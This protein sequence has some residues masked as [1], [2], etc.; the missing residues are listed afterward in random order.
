MTLLTDDLVVE[1]A[2]EQTATR[3]DNRSVVV[4]LALGYCVLSLG[5]NCI[6]AMPEVRR[7][8][9]MS[10][11]ITSLH[12]SFFGWGLIGLSLGAGAMSRLLSRT[13]LFLSGIGLVGAG[14]LVLSFAA[15]T[16]LSL[17]GTFS[18]GLGSAAIVLVIPAAVSARF[19][20]RRGKLLS[21]L[22]VAPTLAGIVM[23]LAFALGGR[24]GW[25]WRL[26]IRILM[27]L[28]VVSALLFAYRPAR[29]RLFDDVDSSDPDGLSDS[30]VSVWQL[31]KHAPVRHRWMIQV[32]QIAA[33]FA[34]GTWTAVYLREVG[35]VSA[36]LAPLGP[37]VWAGGMA[38]S[39]F[40]THWIVGVAGKQLEAACF[41]I[42]VLGSVSLILVDSLPAM[43][44]S[45]AV[46]ALGFGPMYSLGVD[47]LFINAHAAG[48]R[49]DHSISALAAL[50]SGVAVTAGPVVVGV[51]SDQFALRQAMF[52]TPGIAVACFL[53]ASTRWR[54]EAG[55]LG[56]VVT[57]GDS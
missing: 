34:F 28:V 18:F 21:Q 31:L 55:A 2:T 49:D 37:M 47:R 15:N 39:R 52:F 22:N 48:I 54:H 41:G 8:I 56:S 13:A 45:I 6:V 20:H 25:S 53:L 50:A 24:F 29:Q 16:T 11:T 3:A 33:E 10:D 27:P 43:L 9:P 12:G 40:A 23:P 4:S 42:V 1:R 35:N 5:L 46:T 17:L 57:D 19:P 51:L 26:P 36:A 44:V 7:A 32:V 38:L 14:A 30:H